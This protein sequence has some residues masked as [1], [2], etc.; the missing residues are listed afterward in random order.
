MLVVALRLS[1][2][3]F[4][5]IFFLSVVC[6]GLLLWSTVFEAKTRREGGSGGHESVRW[7]SLCNM[8]E[9][10]PFSCARCGMSK[11]RR[12]CNVKIQKINDEIEFCAN[13]PF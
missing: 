7:I 4:C 6:L 3:S 5:L 8:P 13:Q 9:I 11:E 1:Y 10:R 12:M 2:L